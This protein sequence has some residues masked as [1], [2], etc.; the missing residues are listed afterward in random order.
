MKIP[1]RVMRNAFNQARAAGVPTG[2]YAQFSKVV[3]A[4]VSAQL[5][6][7]SPPS[8]APG[9]A[10]GA[11][12]PPSPMPMMN[13]GIPAPDPAKTS[14]WSSLGRPLIGMIQNQLPPL[15]DVALGY[16][17]NVVSDLVPDV[18]SGIAGAIGSAAS[19]ASP[20]IGAVSAVD[21]L[22]S[23]S[24]VLTALAS[25]VFIGTGAIKAVGSAIGSV[26][27]DMFGGGPLPPS[28]A[29]VAPG[30]TYEALKLL[31]EE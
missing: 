28:L 27:D 31:K 24:P 7:Q 16:A 15:S 3:R 1:A 2:T 9:L 19:A 10:P 20:F 13:I 4:Y 30:K 14:A 22:V 18:S 17:G 25:P 5:A 8:P 21:K 11:S 12:P 26:F 29:P 6:G 23:S